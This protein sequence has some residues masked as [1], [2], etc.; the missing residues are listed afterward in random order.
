MNHAK[1]LIVGGGIAG[2]SAAEAIRQND[3]DGSIAIVSDEPYR[4]Y[5][6]IMLSKPNFFL[7]KL[8][9]S[10]VWLKKESWYA[11]QKIDTFFGKKAITFMPEQKTVVLDDG[12][13][14]TYEKLLLAPGVA[15]IQLPAQ[16]ADLPGVYQLRTLDDG[17]AI[18]SAVK[19]VRSAVVVGGGFIGFEMCDM[20]RLAGKEV[21]LVIREKYYWDPV[22]DEDSGHMI[23]EA[24]ERGGVKIVRN[25]LVR[26]MQGNGK[27]EAAMLDN[28]QNIPCDMVI[29]G[30]GAAA[31]LEA[32]RSAGIAVNRGIIANEFLETNV[33]DV[34]AAGDAAE[35]H[36]LVLSENVQLGNWVNAQTQGRIAGA[37][38]AGK[39]QPFIFVSFYTTQGFGITI[40]F[41]GDARP[42]SDRV[43]IPRGSKAEGSY[44]RLIEVGGELVGA[45]MINRTQELGAIAQLIRQDVKTSSLHQQLSDTSIDLKSL[46]APVPMPILVPQKAA[47]TVAAGPAQAPSARPAPVAVMPKP[48][49]KIRIGWFSFSCCE[50]STVIF[51][52]LMNEHWQEWK[53]T[54]DFRHARVLQKNNV[55]DEMDI[56]FIEGAIASEEQ[57]EKVR[58]IRALSKRLVAVGACAVQ[59]LPAGQRNMFSEEQKKTVAFLLE[60]FRAAGKVRR[61]ADVVKV[62]CEVPGCPMDPKD[63]MNKLG[64]LIKELSYDVPQRKPIKF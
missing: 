45:T 42:G 50:D 39:H 1:Y 61:V 3:L 38:M 44:S 2:H 37:N 54:I 58:K 62:D 31:S 29:A 17:K 52:E 48:Q 9:L 13:F 14:L 34:W 19:A 26:E 33:R 49:K 28:G 11:E 7:E 12:S 15:P 20:L 53:K 36:D 30:I 5:S 35:F 21:T 4:L 60:R 23:E 25:A 57:A 64:N 24:L 16:G 22:L 59:A 55:L 63:F 46:G 32:V 56:A 8:P 41:V 51:T 47:V 18:I 10:S 43:Y 27:V 40:G 6:R